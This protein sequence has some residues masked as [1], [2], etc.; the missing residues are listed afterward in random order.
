MQTDTAPASAT[1]TESSAPHR[2]GIRRM[3]PDLRAVCVVWV[4]LLS[5]VLAVVLTYAWVP[6]DELYHVSRTGI[7]GGA[8]RA[9]VLLNF[10]IA[11]IAIAQTGVVIGVL[12]ANRNAFSQARRAALGGVA[13]AS[14]ALCLVT[15]L[16][17]VVDQGNLDA[18]PVN[19]LPALGVA[20]SVALT[21]VALRAV[22]PA[23]RWRWTTWDTVRVVPALALSLLALPWILADLGIYVGDVPGIGG[24]FMSREVPAGETLS[25]VHLGHHHGLDGVIFTLAA[26]AL[27]PALWRISGALRI[28]LAGYLALML[29]YGLGNSTE[30]FWGE[31]IVKRGWTA[32]KIPSLLRPGLTSEWML[33]LSMVAVVWL[34]ALAVSARRGRVPSTSTPAPR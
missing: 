29:V 33:L 6:L 2:T 10:P 32:T 19:A 4:L 15:A 16:P 18:R 13:L 25:A 24:W 11:F 17:G 21:I 5:V 8:S 34:L 7:A 23:G 3:Q 9:L 31:Q 12:S 27:L 14:V 28:A 22:A 20:L 26:F 1:T 30:D